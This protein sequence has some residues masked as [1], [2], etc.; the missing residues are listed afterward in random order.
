MEDFESDNPRVLQLQEVEIGKNYAIVIT[1]NGGLWRYVI[2]DTVKFTS[3][4][5]YRI[6]VSGRTKHFIKAVG[7]ELIIENAVE[8]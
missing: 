1:T 8:G 4:D 7:Q 5:P 6:L 3:K 2:G